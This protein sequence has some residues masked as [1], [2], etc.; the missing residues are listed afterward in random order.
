[1]ALWKDHGDESCE[2]SSPVRGIQPV[3]FYLS[4]PD[5]HVSVASPP[6]PSR[7][8]QGKKHVSMY[9][10]MGSYEPCPTESSIHDSDIANMNKVY[11][12]STARVVSGCA[13]LGISFYDQ[14]EEVMS[15]AARFLDKHRF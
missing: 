10:L 4:A 2:A 14:E 8:C 11:L 9:N 15:L 5:I 12:E 1:M 7:G 3:S 6:R 13:K